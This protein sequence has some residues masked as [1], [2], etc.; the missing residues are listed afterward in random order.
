[1][2]LIFGVD[3]PSTS[4]TFIVYN[5]RTSGIPPIDSVGGWD[6]YF[7]LIVAN[8]SSSILYLLL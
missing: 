3:R 5:A 6:G 2:V 4:L 1:M 7:G 8:L